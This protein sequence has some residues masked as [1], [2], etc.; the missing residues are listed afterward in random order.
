MPRL[1]VPPPLHGL[2]PKR[3]DAR[4]LVIKVKYG[5][6]LKRFN[7]CV[8][9]PHF[10]LNLAALRSK[11][12]SAFKFSEDV[13]F[14]LTYTDEDGDV[15]LL[16]DDNDLYDAAIRQKLNPLRIN[17]ELKSS[18]AEAPQTKHQAS[19]SRSPMS[20]ALEDQ[21]AQVKLAIDEALKFVPEQVPIVLA[22]LSHDLCCKASSSAPS[23]AE[24]LD[25]LS[26]LIA[27]K[28][29]MQ[30]SNGS[31]DCSSGSSSGRQQTMGRLNIKNESEFMTVSALKPLNMQ[32]SGSSKS[33]GL[34]GV[35]VEDIKAKVEHAS[36]YP[37]VEDPLISTSSGGGKIDYKGCT[38]AQG[39]GKS[40]IYS[41]WPPVAT[42]GHGAPTLHSCPAPNVTEGLSN[43]LFSL[44]HSYESFGP[45][46][47]KNGGFNS[48]F[49]PPPPFPHYPLQS[50]RA[51]RNIHG[52]YPPRTYGY[53]QSTPDKLPSVS[54]YE[55]YSE[56]ICSIGSPYRDLS[57]KH[58]SM[59]QHT[60]HIWIQCDGCG[61]TPITGSRY[62]SNIKD[63]YD[64]CSACFSR[65]GNETE[66]TRID[67]PTLAS[68]SL[69]DTNKRRQLLECRFIKDVSVPD[70][71]LMAPSTPFTKI[72]RMHNNGSTM[73]PFGTQLI[74][75]GGDQFA[76][77]NSVKL[78]I[79]VDGFPIDQEINIG[80]DFVAP[81]KP[82]CY[83]SYWRLASPA[84][85]M[86]GQRVWVLIQVEQPVQTSRNKQTT[87]NLNLPPI[88]SSTEWRPFFDMNVEPTDI[89]YEYPGSTISDNF[90]RFSFD[91]STK[92]KESEFVTVPTAFEPVLVPITDGLTSSAGAEMASMPAGVPAPEAVP[93]PKPVIVLPSLPAPA[94]V[95]VTTVTPLAAA[96]APVSVP[97][98][99]AAISVP[100]AISAAASVPT[101]PLPSTIITALEDKLLKE[102][103]HMGFRRADLNKEV[104]RRNEYNLEQTIDD[105]CGVYEWDPISAELHEL[106]L[107]MEQR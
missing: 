93:L 97:T 102:L 69:K 60:L 106:G 10:D 6:T 83:V 103:E 99:P 88:G 30:P 50:L 49:P 55:P 19:N 77:Y 21:L 15:V 24:M 68:R 95:T 66:Y 31:A 4:D 1:S 73:W 2:V 46:G 52:Y 18:R 13:E 44:G 39:K 84:G 33:V 34:K 8:N 28:S 17:V 16:N 67:R 51:D 3:E 26:K 96:V 71:T 25:R 80:V 94:P 85:E 11:I 105:L 91:E 59:P 78:G 40:A 20:T 38:D 72:W 92:L 81:A 35:L 42:I 90:E 57:D 65:M 63:D 47:M 98:V 43:E 27:P 5:C 62:K 74:W 54:P 41:A 23:L 104:L 82:G 14:V 9:G 101:A 76:C 29:N 32:N 48:I 36:G 22:K 53:S 58:K 89:T 56:G 7:A 100:T 79:S 45:N 87:I 70:G 61:V 64:L 86:F 37:L 75:V 107:L 12:A